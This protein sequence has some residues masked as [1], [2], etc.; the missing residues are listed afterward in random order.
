MQ[1][2]MGDGAPGSGDAQLAD[3]RVGIGLIGSGF[4]GRCH[5]Y[6][7][8]AAPA[9][10]DIPEPVLAVLADVDQATAEHAAAA[11]G[12]CSFDLTKRLSSP[13]ADPFSQAQT[14]KLRRHLLEHLLG[15]LIVVTLVSLTKP[16]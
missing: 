16:W 4:M 7:F 10:F 13:R 9:L 11:L 8:R 5:A 2:W 14:K 15:T 6:A 12:F 3:A 1:I